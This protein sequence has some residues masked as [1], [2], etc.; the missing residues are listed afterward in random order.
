MSLAI[1][2]AQNRSLGSFLGG[3][4]GAIGGF[5]T[6]GPGGAVAGAQAGAAIGTAITGGGQ[7]PPANPLPG[8][9]LNLGGFQG[10]NFG[11]SSGGGTTTGTPNAAGQCAPG[12]AKCNPCGVYGHGSHLNTRT[13]QPSKKHGVQAPGTWCVRRR[14]MNPA[15][16][17]ALRRADRRAHAFLRM[18]TKVVRHFTAKAKKGRAYV[19][20]KRKSR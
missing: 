4:V 15:N 2:T 14:H 18:S 20:F 9:P 11:P 6:G 13:L 3:V 17:R 7:T 1:P 12:V 19:H 16:F 10:F 8:K 5:V